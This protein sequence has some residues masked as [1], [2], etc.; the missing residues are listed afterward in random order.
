MVIVE[1]ILVICICLSR[2]ISLIS[3]KFAKM[4]KQNSDRTLRSDKSTLSQPNRVHIISK[5]YFTTEL[6]KFVER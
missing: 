5:L 3:V 2:R 6:Q 1:K 4:A